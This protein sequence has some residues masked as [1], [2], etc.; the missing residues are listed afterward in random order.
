[1]SPGSRF[2]SGDILERITAQRRLDVAASAAARPVEELKV[3]ANF[4]FAC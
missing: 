3:G 1:M 2:Q 4:P